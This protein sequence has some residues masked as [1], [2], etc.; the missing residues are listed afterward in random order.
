MCCGRRIRAAI[1]R[2]RCSVSNRLVMYRAIRRWTTVESSTSLAWTVP[3][4]TPRVAMSAD[5]VARD[6]PAVRGRL[7]LVVTL[8]L[9]MLLFGTVAATVICRSGTIPPGAVGVNAQGAAAGSTVGG[10][11]GAVLGTGALGDN[12]ES[13]EEGGFF[14]GGNGCGGVTG[15]RC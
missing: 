13:G 4:A 12:A 8:V 14:R 5:R 6:A 3:N 11:T 2:R 9:G 1:D 7:R 10:D 15:E